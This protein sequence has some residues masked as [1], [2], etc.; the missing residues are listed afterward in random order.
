MLIIAIACGG[1]LYVVGRAN[2]AKS[3][4]SLQDIAVQQLRSQLT[5]GSINCAN[6]GNIILPGVAAQ[7]VTC[8]TAGVPVTV[9][10]QPVAAVP[11]MVLSVNNTTIF[12]GDGIVSVG[13]S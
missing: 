12:S 11:R 4:M 5:S 7:A 6:P 10:G 9:E 13:G 1:S 2:Q 3:A 8:V